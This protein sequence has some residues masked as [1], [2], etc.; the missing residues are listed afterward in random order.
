M[1]ASDG[2]HINQ[3]V[4]RAQ[5]QRGR[6]PEV[7]SG[8]FYRSIK[9]DSRYNFINGAVWENEEA[10]WKGGFRVLIQPSCEAL[11]PIAGTVSHV[12]GAPVTCRLNPLGR[13]LVY[14]L[15]LR[16]A[17]VNNPN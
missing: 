2:S 11:H 17:E 12:G 1:E 16:Q 6:F 13:P 4:F 14:E 5:G 9:Q 3:R 8:K 7:V 15:S 10:Y